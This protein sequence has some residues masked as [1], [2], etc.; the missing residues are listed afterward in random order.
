MFTHRCAIHSITRRQK[1]KEVYSSVF[2]HIDLHSFKKKLEPV[3]T[4]C[5]LAQINKNMAF[6]YKFLKGTLVSTSVALACKVNSVSE[7]L[8]HQGQFF[9]S[10]ILCGADKICTQETHRSTQS[11][12]DANESV[13]AESSL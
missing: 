13:R 5:A 10:C 12:L 7:N 8:K 4:V 2:S 1:K 3:I 6:Q 9:Q 11:L